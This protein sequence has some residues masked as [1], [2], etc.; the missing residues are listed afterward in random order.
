MIA[1]DTK[2]KQTGKEADVK[3]FQSIRAEL[4]AR[5]EQTY[6]NRCERYPN[7]L[8]F[9]YELGRLYRMNGKVNDAIRELQVAKSDPRK[10][11]VCMLWL[12]DCFY[13]IKQYP[14]AMSHY[15]TAIQD[16]PDRDQENK[17][18]AYVR[19]G[20]LALGLKDLARAE[21]Y[22]T[23][24]ASMDYTYPKISEYLERLERLKTEEGG[25]KPGDEKKSDRNSDED[26]GERTEG[27]QGRQDEVEE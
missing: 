1:A 6:R 9:R 4:M 5:Q 24:L 21:K 7:N 17:K 27:K 12:G 10:R 13:S 22:L 18:M 3:Q 11:G 23:T 20:K 19:A 2:A 16:I 26:A 15:E 25:N 14:L 8:T